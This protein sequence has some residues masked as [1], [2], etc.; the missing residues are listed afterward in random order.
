MDLNFAAMRDALN[1]LTEISDRPEYYVER[2]KASQAAEAFDWKSKQEELISRWK[3][4]YK[5]K[6]A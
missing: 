5:N 2:R 4:E 1:Y 6:M 3:S